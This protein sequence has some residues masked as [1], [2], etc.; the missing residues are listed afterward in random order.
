MS[1]LETSPAPS[2]DSALEMD[3]R[4]GQSGGMGQ[5]R[6]VEQ[7]PPAPVLPVIKDSGTD[8][9]GL[10]QSMLP[11]SSPEIQVGEGTLFMTPMRSRSGSRASTIG[12]ID[13]GK[14]ANL[15]GGKSPTPFGKSPRALPPRIGDQRLSGHST[16]A[17]YGGP[18]PLI[19][20]LRGADE[21]LSSL[22]ASS[23]QCAS[24]GA[25]SQGSQ[26]AL[27]EGE[28]KDVD[29]I[30][31][32]TSR[33]LASFSH[34][35]PPPS[36]PGTYP[37]Y[38]ALS[39]VPHVPE[40]VSPSGAAAANYMGGVSRPIADVVMSEPT[41]RSKVSTTHESMMV[42][43]PPSP[44]SDGSRKDFH[45][46]VDKKHK[47]TFGR[48]WW[49]IQRQEDSFFLIRTIYFSAISRTPNIRCEIICA[50]NG[51]GKC[52]TRS[53]TRAAN[54]CGPDGSSRPIAEK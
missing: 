14:M 24:P 17:D 19:N 21:M 44:R 25:I 32:R 49:R 36:L 31:Q 1:S 10:S 13:S 34:S 53:T 4:R 42:S 2:S 45:G 54:H 30:A 52:R 16:P 46:L 40:G 35:S 8:D 9:F 11:Q 3:H 22:L 37:P 43:G 41:I 18:N 15:Q 28:P 38:V 26:K 7:S 5:E 51:P 12:R 48:R 23:R 27:P 33:E 39:S 47:T 50:E 29:E 20:T 6:S